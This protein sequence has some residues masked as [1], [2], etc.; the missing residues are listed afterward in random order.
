MVKV[1][2]TIAKDIAIHFL[3][4]T[5]ERYTSAMVSKTIVQ[6][7]KLLEA[8]YNKQEIIDSI[9][10]VVNRTSVQ[11]YSLGYIS[12]A[13][14]SILMKLKEED[15]SKRIKEIIEKQKEEHATNRIEV[16]YDESSERNKNKLDRFGTE[17]RERK[18]S[19]VDML[20]E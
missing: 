17:S 16:K 18:E 8:G 10:Y 7:K 14:N 15:E 4:S 13:I 3:N 2:G 11:M 19:I 9:D 6:A 20:K 1:N 5:Q 12:T